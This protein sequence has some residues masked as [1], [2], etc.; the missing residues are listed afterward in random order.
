MDLSELDSFIGKIEPSESSSKAGLPKGLVKTSITLQEE[1][2]EKVRDLAWLKRTK[3]KDVLS[4]MISNSL[5][6]IENSPITK[7]KIIS[8]D[9]GW[10]KTTIVLPRK[11]LDKLKAVALVRRTTIRELLYLV[12]QKHLSNIKIRSSVQEKMDPIS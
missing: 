10:T 7:D 11:H 6:S 12:L 9:S 3:I 5:D 1:H 4:Q 2:L 8:L